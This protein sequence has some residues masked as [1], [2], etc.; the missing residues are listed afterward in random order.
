[1][2]RLLAIAKY[3]DRYVIPQAHAELAERLMEQQG[4]CGLDF[5]GGPGNCGMIGRPHAAD[6][7][8]LHAHRSDPTE[9]DIIEMAGDGASRG[10]DGELMRRASPADAE[11]RRSTSSARCCS[12]TPTTSCCAGTRRAGR[13][14]RD[15]PR[16]PGPPSARRA[17][18]CLVDAAEPPLRRSR[19]TTSQTFDLHKR[20]GLYLTF[21]AHGDKRERGLALLRLKQL[22][23]AA[24]LPLEGDRAAR[25][26]AG[27]ARV[28]RAAP[29]AARASWCCASTARARAGP[30]RPARARQPVRARARR[31]LRAAR[32]PRPRSIARRSRASPPR[33]RRR[34]WSGWSRSRRRR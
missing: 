31:R 25:L 5:E 24:G 33:G 7:A 18:L 22:Y 30:P 2:Y 15:A 27:D 12:S 29:P 11:P 14:G 20:C 10:R 28:R 4:A 19:G 8:E 13:R 32:R 9:L 1:M 17:F 6:D 26:P 3:E 34:S 21:Y 23:R 16:S